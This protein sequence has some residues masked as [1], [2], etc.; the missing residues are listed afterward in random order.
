MYGLLAAVNSSWRGHGLTFCLTCAI[1]RCSLTTLSDIFI[2][3][4]LSQKKNTKE[5]NQNYFQLFFNFLFFLDDW[6]YVKVVINSAKCGSVRG[7]ILKVH[8]W[9]LIKLPNC[10]TQQDCQDEIRCMVSLPT[11]LTNLSA[12]ISLSHHGRKR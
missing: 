12:M 8:T 7:C 2:S 4:Q 10:V 9:L 3:S 6:Q 1:G 11:H 5:S